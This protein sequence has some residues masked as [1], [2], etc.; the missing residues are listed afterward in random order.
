LQDTGPTLRRQVND[1]FPFLESSPS[2]WDTMEQ[3]VDIRFEATDELLELMDMVTDRAPFPFPLKRQ[4]LA[5]PVPTGEQTIAT[6][7]R[8]SSSFMESAAEMEFA[9]AVSGSEIGR[10]R[11]SQAAFLQSDQFGDMREISFDQQSFTHE[12]TS[13]VG[14]LSVFIVNVYLKLYS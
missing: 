14:T 6:R 1:P 10:S 3:R 4:R 13:E 8:R 5:E 12:R 9:R 11:A 2:V 7:D